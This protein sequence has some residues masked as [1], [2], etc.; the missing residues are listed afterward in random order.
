MSDQTASSDTHDQTEYIKTSRATGRWLGQMKTAL[1][2]R[3]FELFYT[4]EPEEAG[5]DNSAPTPTEYVMATLNGCLAVVIEMVADEQEFGFEDVEFDSR[6]RIDRRGIAGTADVSPQFQRVINRVRIVS[7][8]SRDRLD[9]LRD[10]VTRRCPVFNLLADSGIE[11]ELQ[12]EIVSPDDDRE[13]LFKPPH[14]EP[15]FSRT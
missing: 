1:R 7:D 5:G 8:E 10:E 12:W 14:R 4:G 15:S 6:G 11:I 13:P 3:N 2:I 9:A